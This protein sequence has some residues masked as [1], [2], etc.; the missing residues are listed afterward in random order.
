MSEVLRRYL[1]VLP[2]AMISGTSHSSRILIQ[3]SSGKTA[4]S[5]VLDLGIQDARCTPSRGDRDNN[6]DYRLYRSRG[7]KIGVGTR[8][9]E[10]KYRPAVCARSLLP[11]AA[12][13]L[14]TPIYNEHGAARLSH[15]FL[16]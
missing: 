16:A 13:L 6:I 7:K 10:I 14:L 1:Q 12:T 4:G 11:A 9:N 15:S 8:T 3:I 2:K 5:M